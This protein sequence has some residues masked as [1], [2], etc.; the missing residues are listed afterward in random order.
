MKYLSEFGDCLPNLIDVEK[1][2]NVLYEKV[3]FFFLFCS[4]FFI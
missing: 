4:D 1:N 3:I 2:K